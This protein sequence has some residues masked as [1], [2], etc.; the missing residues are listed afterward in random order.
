MEEMAGDVVVEKVDDKVRKG[1]E[2]LEM[3]RDLEEVTQYHHHLQN[4]ER[5]VSGD[6]HTCWE[7]GLMIQQAVVVPSIWNRVPPRL[8]QILSTFSLSA[9]HLSSQSPPSLLP[10]P[11]TFS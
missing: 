11:P 3:S 4:F 10:P 9:P 6:F 5:S 2:V 8:D 7:W 1:M